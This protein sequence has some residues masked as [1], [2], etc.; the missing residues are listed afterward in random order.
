MTYPVGEIKLRWRDQDLTA[1]YQ[2][3]I[4]L[5]EEIARLLNPPKNSSPR[6]RGSLPEG[7]QEDLSSGEMKVAAVKSILLIPGR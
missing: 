1:Q 4:R 2:D 6:K 3:L 5:R 7:G